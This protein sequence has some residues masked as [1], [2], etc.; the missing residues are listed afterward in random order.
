MASMQEGFLEATPPIAAELTLPRRLSRLP[1]LAYNLWWTWQ[2]QAQ[3]LF[4]RIDFSVWEET[5]HNPVQFLRKVKRPQLNAA[6]SNVGYMETYGRVMESFDRYLDATDTWYRRENPDLLNRPIAYFSTEYGLHESIQG[7]AGGLG[8]LAGDLLKEASDLGIPMVG[9]GFLY[10]LGYFR[11]SVTEDGWQ[12]A[13]YEPLDFS[14]LPVWPVIGRDGKPLTVNV[15]LPERDLSA[16]LWQ[17]RVGRIPLYLLDSNVE[18]NSEADRELTARLYTSEAEQ[19]ISQEIILGIGGVRALRALGYNPAAWHLNEGHSAFAL[20]E[21]AREYVAAGRT[22]AE[23]REIIRKTTVFTTHTPVPAGADEF[24]LLLM[25]KFFPQYWPQLGLERE[26]FLDIARHRH[27]WGETFSMPVLALRMSDHAN[28]VS[29]LHGRVARKMYNHLWP[30]LPEEKVP[31][32]H[33]TNG[34]HSQTWLAPPMA[35]LFD[36]F[37]GED[38]RERIDQ[39]AVWDGVCEIPDKQ[40][41]E[42]RIHLKQRLV[43]HIR[44]RSRQ[45]WLSGKKH[46]VQIVNAGVL[47]DPNM[48]IIGFARRFATYKRAGL[49]LRRPDRL[50]ALLNRPNMPVQFIFAGKAHPADEPAKRLLQDVYRFAKRHEAGGRFVFLEDYDINLARYLVQG[51]DVWLNTP[52]RPLEASGTSGQKAALNGVLNFSVLDG[53]W[54]EGY[55]GRNGWA[56]GDDKENQN[57]EAQ[58]AEDTDSLYAVLENEIIPL[59]YENRTAENIPSEWLVRVRESVRTISATFNTRRMLKEYACDLYLPAI[60]QPFPEMDDPSLGIP[61]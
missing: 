14:N 60:R 35:S 40:L 29:E 22:F 1:E 33:I 23:A 50:L 36:E 61:T 3:D 10:T 20:L 58:N 11:Q 48:L 19:R 18:S 44:D 13:L 2:P 28:G 4:S 5:R 34:I 21:R 31:I 49:L 7:Y 42:T 16:R 59:Y 37:M 6:L 12:E 39:Q 54:R 26:G 56:I 15:A 53:W 8:V 25:D 43:A 9:L 52:L 24:P 41:W 45:Q 51:A 47:L 30:D 57:A 27:S 55:N 46:P 17:V 38:W 32:R